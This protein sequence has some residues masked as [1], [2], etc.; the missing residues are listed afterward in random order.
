[1]KAILP[2]KRFDPEAAFAAAVDIMESNVIEYANEKF[3]S[4]HS[5]WS[6][7]STPDEIIERTQSGHSVEWFVGRD[8]LIYSYVSRGTGPRNIYSDTPMFFPSEFTP[9]T[10]K[11]SAVSGPGGSGG[12][13]IGPVWVVENHEIEPREFDVTVHDLVSKYIPRQVNRINNAISRAIWQ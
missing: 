11:G 7:E 13:T 12:V 6:A 5:T 2:T 10:K 9:K 4:T 3:G 8:G 1:M